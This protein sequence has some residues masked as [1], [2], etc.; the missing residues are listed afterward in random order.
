MFIFKLSF[1]YYQIFFKSK[2]LGC[3]DKFVVTV[4]QFILSSFF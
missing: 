2:T 4:N 3:V 1:L